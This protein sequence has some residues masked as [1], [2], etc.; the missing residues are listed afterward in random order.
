MAVYTTKDIQPR[1]SSTY[2]FQQISKRG[3]A[4]GLVPGSEEARDWFRDSASS[5]KQVDS[6]RLMQNKKRLFNTI[7]EAD[8]GR[9]YMFF[10]DPKHKETLPYYDKFPLIYIVEKYSD[11]FLGINLHYLPL[12]YR[13]RLMDALYDIEMNDRMREDKKLKLT[14]GLLKAASKFKYFKP[15]VKRYL[16][17]HVRSRF[18]YV[19]YEEWDIAMA[20]PTER[21]AKK[22]KGKVWEDSK[23]IIRNQ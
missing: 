23:R 11:G 22:S 21:F 4:E 10:Y 16:Y 20:L 2:L 8:M 19:P 18:L 15:C 9:M 1:S 5:F 7:V 14:Y 13:A 17:N 6:R 3:R 12:T